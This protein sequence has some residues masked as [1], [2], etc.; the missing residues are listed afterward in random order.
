MT[1]GLRIRPA[2]DQDVD[3]IADFIA[4]RSVDQA[5]RFYDSIA[6]TYQLILEAPERWP[7]CEL[8]LERLRDVRKRSVVKFR[9]HF[10]F[11]RI[12]A[13]MV[14]VV[15]VFHGAQDFPTLLREDTE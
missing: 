1:Y 13:D 3:Y 10:V 6:A 9:N 8:E 5:V 12:D 7:L 11:Y 15:R 14:E 2:A 4:Q